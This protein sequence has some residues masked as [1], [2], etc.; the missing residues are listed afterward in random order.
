MIASRVIRT[1]GQSE[2]GLAEILA[3]R[4]KELDAAGNP[5][6]AFLAS[7]VEGLKVR[8]TAKAAR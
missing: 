1:W 5:T 2:S 3:E 6:F 7:G 8:I 4:I